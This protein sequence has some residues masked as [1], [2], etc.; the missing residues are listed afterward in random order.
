MPGFLME[1]GAQAAQILGRGGGFVG[2]AGGAFSGAFFVVESM[3]NG[4]MGAIEVGKWEDTG[5]WMLTFCHTVF[6]SAQ[7]I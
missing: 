3:G 6:A 7:C 4:S 5:R 2:F 1:L